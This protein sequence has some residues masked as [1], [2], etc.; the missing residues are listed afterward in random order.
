MRLAF[1]HPWVSQSSRHLKSELSENLLSASTGCLV[2][3]NRGP[4]G[5]EGLVAAS[6][7]RGTLWP[8]GTSLIER[9]RWPMTER[10]GV[11]GVGR[12]GSNMARRLKDCGYAIALPPVIPQ[13]VHVGHTSPRRT[14]PI[15]DRCAIPALVTR[16]GGGAQEEHCLAL[17]PVP[18]DHSR[19]WAT[20]L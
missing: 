19:S 4:A 8:N 13:R 20:P 10:I 14:I 7:R 17:C 12:M 6:Q 1:G 11:V 18:F 3:M 2:A 15:S 16:D 5:V 9:E